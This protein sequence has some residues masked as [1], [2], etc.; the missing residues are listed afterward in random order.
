MVFGL[1]EHEDQSFLRFGSFIDHLYP[2]FLQLLGAKDGEANIRVSTVGKSPRLVS[3]FLPQA[4]TAT[5]ILVICELFESID[6]SKLSYKIFEDIDGIVPRLI[7]LLHDEKQDRPLYIHCL[8]TILR[9]PV[10]VIDGN[11][12]KIKN[13][14]AQSVY[15]IF[16]SN[17]KWGL[18]L[19]ELFSD[20]EG[21]QDNRF[22]DFKIIDV[23]LQPGL[24]QD[25]SAK[26][27]WSLSPL[28][29]KS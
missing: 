27:I 13:Q 17:P 9:H 24:T 22:S 7:Q 16:I 10:H 14:L 23:L 15:I 25:R 26:S 4:Q 28:S 5:C 18:L 29:L 2:I 12:T 21:F 11:F 1:D 20:Q 6:P 8:N 3:F 19:D